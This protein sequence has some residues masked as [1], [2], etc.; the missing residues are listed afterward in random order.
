[1]PLHRFKLSLFS[2]RRAA[3]GVAMV[4]HLLWLSLAAVPAI[5]E[6]VAL[7]PH[8]HESAGDRAMTSSSAQQAPLLA[9]AHHS[10]DSPPCCDHQCHCINGLCAVMRTSLSRVAH[11][12]HGDVI[13][14]SNHT[15]LLNTAPDPQFRPPIQS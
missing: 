1:M 9:L 7:A 12:G 3:L 4:L 15:T 6:P 10:P 2:R 11:T 8:C 5:A 13:T 14:D